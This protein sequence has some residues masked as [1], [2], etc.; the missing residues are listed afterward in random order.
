MVSKIEI[1]EIPHQGSYSF[2]G[3]NDCTYMFCFLRLSKGHNFKIFKNNDMVSDQNVNWLL[4]PDMEA[5]KELIEI[6]LKKQ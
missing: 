5:A 1:E 4:I 3:S 2:Y 6:F